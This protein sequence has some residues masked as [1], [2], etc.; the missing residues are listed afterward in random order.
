MKTN[1]FR[2][3]TIFGLIALLVACS[4]RR[5]TWL[6]RNSHAMST[7]Y[8]ILYNGDIALEDG[9]NE[10]KTTY[11]D[12]FWEILPVE[13][14][15]PEAEKPV[16]PVASAPV[17]TGGKEPQIPQ[18][19]KNANF[20]RAEEKA[21]KAIQ[22]HSMN[23]GGTE[24]NSQMDEAHLLLGKARYYDKRYLPALEA[25]NYVLYKY[26]KSSRIYEVK[27][28]REKTNMRLENDGLAIT[29][30]QKLLGDEKV[31]LNDQVYADANAALAQAFLN[32]EE[33]DSAIA[34]LKVA[35]DKTKA[36]EEKAR[37]RFIVAQ[38]FEQKKEKDSAYKYY[39]EV[40]DMNRSSPR[41]YVIQAHGRQ[42]LQFDY[43]KG[44]TVV[45]LEKYRKLL[46]D[47]DNRAYLDAIN[48][49][50]ALF[51]D[52]RKQPD[53]AVKYY[54][55]SLDAQPQDAYL[56]ASNYRNIAEIYFNKAKYVTAGMY[57]DSTLVHL[58]PRTREFRMIEKKRMNL[59]D[60]IKYEGI[61]TRND[62]I[63]KVWSMPEAARVAYYQ[64]Y[65]DKL[66]IEDEK[67]RIAEEKA[68]ERAENAQN[69]SAND[70]A[71]NSTG[72]KSAISRSDAKS[73]ADAATGATPI[74]KPAKPGEFYFYNAATVAYGKSEFR[75]NWGTRKYQ[76]NWRFAKSS[77]SDTPVEEDREL[78][79]EEIKA[80]ADAAQIAEA[81]YTPD[82]YISQLPTS[83]VVIDSL[84]K[85]RNFAYYQLGVIYKEKFRE[86]QRSA[87]K[88][89]ALLMNNPEERLILPAQYNLYK[90]YEILDKQKAAVVK[91][92]IITQY[93]DSRYA[94]ILKNETLTGDA[95]LTPV[96]A[97]NKLFKEYEAGDY[98]GVLI[99]VEDAID[100]YTGE[101]MLPKFEILKARTV[102]K[103]R[104]LE[105]YKKALNYV[106]L[107][108]PNVEEGKEAEK[109][110]GRD[111][112]MM[113]AM[114]FNDTDPKSWKLLY[115]APNPDAKNIKVLQEKLKKFISERTADQLSQSLDIYTMDMNFV[116]VHGI[117]TENGAEGIASVLKEFKEYK[118]VEKP[119]VISNDNYAIVQIKKN[120]EEYLADPHKKSPKRAAPALKSVDNGPKN[121]TP[122]G[123]RIPKQRPAQTATPSGAQP[124]VGRPPQD[125][126]DPMQSAQPPTMGGSGKTQ[127]TTTPPRK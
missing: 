82:F 39:D 95:A 65:I 60:V 100:Q 114:Q 117:R 4:T 120:L 30:L 106:A 73:A 40:I 26:P 69:A 51:Y 81:K 32:T 127:T 8:N 71:S 112:V 105:E 113:E 7:K 16:E 75:K 85:E 103:L 52:K 38:I 31:K 126:D 96:A 14:M 125:S 49:Q 5:D 13:R 76:E 46:K 10:L 19:S 88:L 50:M 57:Y 36:D 53:M 6:A 35:I 17:P 20:Q 119:I 80:K 116:V 18:Q 83:K 34:R 44:D 123:A 3:I 70:V 89:E 79:E 64:E 15:Q 115:Y 61:A 62:S 1:I 104:G 59:E 37:Y 58:K 74:T 24:V 54:N 21:T 28:W 84:A 56:N 47:R 66:K 107:T 122:R 124:G 22:K 29:N 48:Y 68:R 111:I 109:M 99:K 87:D 12:N 98:K 92:D 67:K 91:N 77:S 72:A 97:F 25:F 41:M 86:Y 93:P 27:V 55:K 45:F 63:I 9:V 121:Q 110:L 118:V 42:S 43:E 2:I 11:G 78:T 90:V 108:Y 94:Q 33:K 23:I 101:E 102:G